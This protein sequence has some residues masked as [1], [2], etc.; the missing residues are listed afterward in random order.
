MEVSGRWVGWKVADGGRTV[1]RG[2]PRPYRGGFRIHMHCFSLKII[3]F[4]PDMFNQSRRDIDGQEIPA[5]QVA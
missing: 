5:C 2:M 3:I 1:G 4:V